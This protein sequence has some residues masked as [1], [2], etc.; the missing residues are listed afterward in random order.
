MMINETISAM[1]EGQLIEHCH[2]I[3]ATPAIIYYFIAV[4]LVTCIVFW[5]G[6]DGVKSKKKITK[7]ILLVTV[8]NAALAA[9][10]Y[11]LPHFIQMINIFGGI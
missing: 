9:G 8:L 10:I 4:T 11:L 3:T 6:V 5:F 2:A 7:L 1:T